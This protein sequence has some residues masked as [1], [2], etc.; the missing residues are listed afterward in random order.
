MYNYTIMKPIHFTLPPVKERR[1]R[2]LF[3]QDLPFRGRVERPK[4]E[5]QRR[6]K[7]KNR[8]QECL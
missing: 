1:H 6:P 7:H 3:D 5:Y 4:T 2:A 8:E